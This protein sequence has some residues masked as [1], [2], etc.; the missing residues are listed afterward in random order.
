MTDFATARR[1]HATCFTDRIGREVVVKHE[2]FFVHAGQRVDI[3]FVF[4]GTESGNH[5]RLCFTAGEEGRTMGT[6]QETD[7]RN[8]GANGLQVTAIDTA[9]GVKNVPAND[10]RLNRLEYSRDFFGRKLRLFNTF[11]EEMRLDLG[12]GSI[13]RCVTLLLVGDLVSVAQIS[14]GNLQNGRFNGRKI[15]GNE[16]AWFLGSNL[17]ELD[18]RV[19]R[20]AGSPYG[21]T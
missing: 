13:D 18:D 6:R 16:I 11:R 4:A 1:T 7:F 14:F 19:E 8:D 15:I 2:G 17:G 9:A 21:R 10:L 3:L 12:L 20:P 5:D